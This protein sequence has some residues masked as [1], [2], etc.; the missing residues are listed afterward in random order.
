MIKL[1]TLVRLLLGRSLPDQTLTAPWDRG[2]STRWL[3]READER[4]EAYRKEV[5]A[6]WPK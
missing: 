2:V 5:V 4:A 1:M 3:R 6:R